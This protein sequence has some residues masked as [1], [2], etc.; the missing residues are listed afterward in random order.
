[1]DC[2]EI[3]F[4]GH[5]VTRLYERGLSKD[6]VLQALKHGELIVDYPDDK[7]YPSRLI[8]GYSGFKPIHVVVAENPDNSVCFIV[9]AYQPD[10]ALWS[11]DFKNRRSPK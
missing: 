5:A 4:S 8:L 6:D 10:S 2:A 11:A 9:T 1:M 3:R 7:P